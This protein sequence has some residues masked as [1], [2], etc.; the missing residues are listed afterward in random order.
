MQQAFNKWK[1]MT[2]DEQNALQ[3]KPY[4]DLKR[5][6]V[7][8]AKRLEALAENAQNDED[9]INHLSDQNDELFNNYKKG[10][11]LALAMWRDNRQMG[12]RKGF[13]AFLQSAAKTRS[14]H[15]GEIMGTNIGLIAALKDKIAELER[16][17]DS[18]ANENEELR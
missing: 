5:R 16:D 9:M 13:S 6:A 11:K 3:K 12:L 7:M 15:L 8:A 1:Y 10:Q 17:N 18:L 14:G 4:A 2:S